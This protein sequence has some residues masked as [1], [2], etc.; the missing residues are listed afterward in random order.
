MLEGV[1]ISSSR[2]IFPTQRSNLF[3]LCLLH[4]QEF[5]TWSGFF[6]TRATWKAHLCNKVNVQMSLVSLNEPDC[7]IRNGVS[8]CVCV[9]Y[10]K[11][12]VREEKN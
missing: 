11:G 6:A 2:G 8:V 4:W 3:L 10:A 9:Y 5:F 12:K 1:A 7:I